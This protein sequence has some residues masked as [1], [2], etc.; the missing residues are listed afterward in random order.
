[1]LTSSHA[2]RQWPFPFPQEGPTHLGKGLKRL[3]WNIEGHQ[4]MHHHSRESSSDKDRPATM[5]HELGTPRL[6]PLDYILHHWLELGCGMGM[7]RGRPWYLHGREPTSQPRIPPVIATCSGEHRIGCNEHLSWLV[8]KLEA[9]TMPKRSTR[10]RHV[11]PYTDDRG[12]C[13]RITATGNVYH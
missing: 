11:L 4:S 6:Q 9:T 8:C 13:H 5:V 7:L 12:V 3:W 1:V 2:T 10:D